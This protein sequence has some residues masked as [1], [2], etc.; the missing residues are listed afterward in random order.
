MRRLFPAACLLLVLYLAWET[1]QLGTAARRVPLAVLL[2]LALLLAVEWVREWRRRQEEPVRMGGYSS[3]LGWVA[4]L[5]VLV[6]AVGMVA[7]PALYLLAYLRIR[8]KEA[9]W[10]SLV[11]AGLTAL[12]LSLLF[13]S[14]LPV[15][16]APGF[17]VR[18]LLP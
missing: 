12:G 8:T 7:G 15:S 4:G 2:P 18:P 9:W 10:L 17:L 11:A 3:A 6:S 13:G 5:P 1:S 16:A 14:I